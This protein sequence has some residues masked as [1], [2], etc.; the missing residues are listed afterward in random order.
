[1]MSPVTTKLASC[2][3]LFLAP[4]WG[5]RLLSWPMLV[6]ASPGL[7]APR[8]YGQVVGVVFYD[9][10]W[11]QSFTKWHTHRLRGLFHSLLAQPERQAFACRQGCARGLSVVDG[12]SHRS[13]MHCDRGIP[14]SIFRPAYDKNRCKPCL[15]P[16]W[17]S[18]N[19]QAETV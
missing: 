3:L 17:Q 6:P 19:H 13:R 14:Q 2:R 5:C 15:I 8:F 18:C 1:M 12:N 4:I 16:Q 11:L 7:D 10:F 9:L